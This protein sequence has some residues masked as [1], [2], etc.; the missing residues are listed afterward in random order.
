MTRTLREIARIS[1]LEGT[2]VVLVDAADLHTMPSLGYLH[3]F[4]LSLLD[5][6]VVRDVKIA[7]LAGTEVLTQLTFMETVAKNRGAPIR[8]FRQRQDALVWLFP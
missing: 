4:V 5:L 1:A 3:Q 7:I 2:A 6:D 8:V